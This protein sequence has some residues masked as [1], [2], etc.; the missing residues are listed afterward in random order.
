MRM[1][2]PNT[3]FSYPIDGI[4]AFSLNSISINS[5]S[6]DTTSNTV[7][8]RAYYT[9]TPTYYML[10]ES[11]SFTG[12]SWIAWS[13]STVQ[14]VLSSGYG[15]KTLYMKLKSADNSLTNVV[16]SSIEYKAPIVAPVLNSISINSG[17]SD[18]DSLFVDIAF[19]SSGTPTHYM[20]S[21]SSDFTG[22]S[23]IAWSGSTVQF[24]LSSGDG[25]K[26]VYA[27]L[28]NSTGESLSV[29]S[30]ITYKAP[31]VT[32]AP[33]LSSISI[34]SGDNTTSLLEVSISMSASGTPTH[35]MLSESSDFTGASWIAWSGS[36]VQFG[37]SS[38]DGLKTVYAKLKNEI[39]ESATVSDSI[40]LDTTTLTVQASSNSISAIGGAI[41]IAVT[42]NANW[43]ATKGTGDIDYTLEPSSGFGNGTII[44]NIS[45]N[46]G[47]L[48]NANIIISAGSI[49]RTISITQLAAAAPSVKSVIAFNN[50]TANTIT[51]VVDNGDT[52]NQVYPAS[53][54]SYADKQLKD[55]NGNL[56][57]WYVNLNNNKYAINDIFTIEGTNVRINATANPTL[58][59][60]GIYAAAV[61]NVCSVVSN[62]AAKT[63]LSFTLPQGSYQIKLLWS[64]SSSL[65][66]TETTRQ[67]C[68]YGLFSG[69]TELASAVVGDVN[70][71]PVNNNQYNNTLLFTLS[72][73]STVDL[74]WWSTANL[75]WRPGLNLIELTK[76]S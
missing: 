50:A 54:S 11:S 61:Y 41:T 18:T 60:T 40:T 73:T 66:I 34:N 49:T 3:T 68:M 4:V 28:K 33:S 76:L 6:V 17:A 1:I 10:S 62:S 25:L 21:E 55:S 69:T 65:S 67:Q 72:A 36:T 47:A 13:G 22:A 35:Y 20:L 52:I 30:S 75:Y 51:T 24:S 39:G 7:S 31:P 37:L 32:S 71:S 15:I 53:H 64:T 59:D 14:F 48:K 8:V 23:W 27:K 16:S 70:F 38:G 63:R 42:S 56:I 44:L 57:N 19:S 9:G 2:I 43:S 29:N 5:G 45:E 58:D 46:E 26:T 12:A 74:A